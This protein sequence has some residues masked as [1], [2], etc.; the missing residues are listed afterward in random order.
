[1]QL[2]TLPSLRDTLKKYD[3]FPNK[4]FGQNFLFDQNITDKIARLAGP[5]EGRTVVEVGP[6]PGGLTRSLLRA[7]AQ[8]VIAIELDKRCLPILQE[9]KEI[10]GDRLE[11]MS[12]DA[13]KV[14]CHELGESPRK[15]IANL[16]Y[17]VATPLLFNWL[18]HIH[19]FE[20]LTLMFQKEVADRIKASP[21]TSNYGRLSVMVQ[22][23]AYVGQLFDLSPEAFFPPPKVTSSVIQLT[24]RPEVTPPDLYKALEIVVKAGFAQRRKMLRSSLRSLGFKD[25]GQVFHNLGISPEAR[26]EELTVDDFTQLAQAYLNSD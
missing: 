25:L 14:K 2:D 23:V 22:K 24:P 15:I 9:L 16:P 3:M 10:S 5:L 20:S 1:M 11:I 12:Q 6:G 19:S 4:K 21:Q 26:A 17:N 8:K 7:E 18:P 13:L